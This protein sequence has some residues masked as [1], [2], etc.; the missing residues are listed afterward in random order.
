MKLDIL[1]NGDMVDALSMI[2]HADTAY[3]KG[4]RLAE[5]VKENIPRQMFEIPIQAV[6]GLSLIHIFSPPLWQ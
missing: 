2:V 1:L 4:R 6:I 3:A 5:K